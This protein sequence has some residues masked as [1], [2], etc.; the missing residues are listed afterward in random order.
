MLIVFFFFFTYDCFTCCLSV[1]RVC[2]QRVHLSATEILRCVTLTK[3]ILYNRMQTL[4][5]NTFV[6]ARLHGSVHILLPL[7]VIK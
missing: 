3:C 4:L 1:I 7:T 2:H 5:E 6:V